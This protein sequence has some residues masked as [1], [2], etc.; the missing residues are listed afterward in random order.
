[1]CRS[2]SRSRSRGRGRGRGRSRS[3][4]RSR[5]KSRTCKI[6]SFVGR[7]PCGTSCLLGPIRGRMVAYLMVLA[8]G[9]YMEKTFTAGGG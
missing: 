8:V 7:P 3:R 1:M 9:S 5:S 4:S 6:S 2:R